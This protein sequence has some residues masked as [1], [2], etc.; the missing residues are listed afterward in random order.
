[1][2]CRHHKNF[3]PLLSFKKVFY[4][5]ICYAMIENICFNLINFVGFCVPDTYRGKIH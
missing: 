1:M 4:S 5:H 2:I 3:K